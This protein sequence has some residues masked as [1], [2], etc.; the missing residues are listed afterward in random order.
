MK[1]SRNLLRAIFKIT[2]LVAMVDILLYPIDPRLA[3]VGSAILF[4]YGFYLGMQAA[5]KDGYR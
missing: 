2:V 1:I 4:P 3:L 5:K